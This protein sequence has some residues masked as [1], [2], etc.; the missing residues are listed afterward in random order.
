MDITSLHQ[1]YASGQSTI[2]SIVSEIYAR[3]EAQGLH[4]IWISIVPTEHALRRAA[5]LDALLPPRAIET[6]PLRSSLRRQRQYRR[7]RSA[8]HRRLSRLCL[9]ASGIGHRRHP[10]RSC[11]RDPHWQDQHGSVRH[12]SRRHAQSL[13]HLLQRLQLELHLRR[14]E[15]GLCRSRRQWPRHLRPR[16]GHRRLRSRS[17]DVQQRDR[18][19]AYLRR[20]QHQR[21]LSRLPHTRLRLHLRRNCI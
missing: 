20:P 15:R 5:E 13:R 4:P 11:R 2:S 9:H 1:A 17:R 6:A 18:P 19:Q 14:L 7:R 3:I 12:R 21:R 16:H 10:P 8:D